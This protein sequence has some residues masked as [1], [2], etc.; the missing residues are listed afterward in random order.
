MN[1]PDEI[2][3]HAISKIAGKWEP[4]PDKPAVRIA[5]LEA[6]A[7]HA[8]NWQM[9]HA[10]ETELQAER[11]GHLASAQRIHQLEAERDEAWNTGFTAGYNEAF[12]RY[13]GERDAAPTSS[14]EKS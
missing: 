9:V 10:L 4:V 11:D 7:K 2:L 6:N 14:G 5:E 12:E 3:G 13:G 1:D 8:P